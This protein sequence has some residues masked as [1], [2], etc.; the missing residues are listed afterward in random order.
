M[1]NS[2]SCSNCKYLGTLWY[3]ES[4]KP[5]LTKL[6]KPCCFVFANDKDERVA[7]NIMGDVNKEQ[8]EMWEGKDA[9]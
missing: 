5:P 3:W 1:T 9:V 7:M 6:Y 4:D 2:K 8:C